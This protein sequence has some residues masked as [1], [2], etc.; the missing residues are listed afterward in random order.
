[1]SNWSRT[2]CSIFRVIICCRFWPIEKI[3]ERSRTCVPLSEARVNAMI[4]A[5]LTCNTHTLWN[6]AQLSGT[7]ARLSSP[8][9]RSFSTH[10]HST[11]QNLPLK[12]RKK[13]LQCLPVPLGA[14]RAGVFGTGTGENT[15]MRSKPLWLNCKASAR[16]NGQDK[17]ILASFFNAL[18][19]SNRQAI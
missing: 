15:D 10:S 8:K 19:P 16:N 3:R 5:N 6:D 1:M 7:L 11:L 12:Q 4:A 18:K 13:C 9:A 17:T 14:G 2:R